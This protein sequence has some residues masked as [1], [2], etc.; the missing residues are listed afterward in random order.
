MDNNN[1]DMFK[2]VEM[3]DKQKKA[4]IDTIF[5]DLDS[6]KNSVMEEE[7]KKKK[8]DKVYSY[9]S[10]ADPTLITKPVLPADLGSFNTRFE[11]FRLLIEKVSYGTHNV[12][13][14]VEGHMDALKKYYQDAS[15]NSKDLYVI[16]AR[17]SDE[18]NRYNSHSQ[19]YEKGYYDGLLYVF[20]SLKRSKELLMAKINKEIINK[21]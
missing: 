19:L 2:V 6:V 1:L 17:V 4:D 16:E 9:T 15:N 18:M 12:N 8:A 10:D 20:K 7:E 5:S 11:C 3:M 21:L 14:Y 13:S